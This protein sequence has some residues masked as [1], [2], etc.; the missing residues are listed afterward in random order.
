VA[1]AIF[2][3]A[4]EQL[5]REVKA[6]WVLQMVLVDKI[7]QIPVKASVPAQAARKRGCAL[8]MLAAMT[9]LMALSPHGA[10]WTQRTQPEAAGLAFIMPILVSEQIFQYTGGFYEC[11]NPEAHLYVHFNTRVE[12][13]TCLAHTAL[14]V[15]QMLS[16]PESVVML[17]S[18]LQCNGGLIPNSQRT[19]DVAENTIAWLKEKA[20]VT[21]DKL[22]YTQLSLGAM[23]NTPGTYFLT[24][25][26][27]RGNLSYGHA[28]GLTF[29]CAYQIMKNNS[30]FIGARHG[31][32]Y[33]GNP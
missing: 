3:A 8:A 5:V 20:C 7:W 4:V 14:H 6:Q 26:I 13:W 12:Y 30:E 1:D 9:P 27:Q 32:R 11:D 31:I 10:E 21:A 25:Q 17:V 23:M 15:L 2:V 19:G 18:A 33:M 29:Y 16:A 28:I 22:E 24:L